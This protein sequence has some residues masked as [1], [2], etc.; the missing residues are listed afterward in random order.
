M[1]SEKER[2]EVYFD[3]VNF[4]CHDWCCFQ[5]RG[6]SSTELILESINLFS[7]QEKKSMNVGSIFLYMGDFSEYPLSFSGPKYSEFTI[8]C[9]FFDGWPEI[10]V[11]C[12]DKTCEMI[13]E[14]SVSEFLYDELFW[15]GN[16]NTHWSR[17]KF[18]E[19][20]ANDVRIKC[21][22][23]HGWYI[24]NNNDRWLTH[25]GGYVSLPDHA[26]YKYL[27]DLQ[28]IG[29]SARTKALMHSNRPLFYQMRGCNEYWFFDLKPFEHY[30]PI[31][32]DLSDF[33]EKFDWANKN[34]EKCIKIA[35]KAFE[36]ASLKLKRKNAV[37]RYKEVLLKVF[38]G[39]DFLSEPSMYIKSK[40]K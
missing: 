9:W 38:S 8:P 34:Y 10:G 12:Y 39:S 32:D 22:D 23:I 6:K 15:I 14:I 5:S 4:I 36:F 2:L 31:M 35:K 40:I 13:R 16:F 17:K 19:M 33:Y 24:N 20:N 11:G 30:I 27:I 7:N 18:Y 3:G 25:T 28:G 29:Y 26:K 21:I 37:E 1:K